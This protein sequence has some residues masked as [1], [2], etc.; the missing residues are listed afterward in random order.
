MITINT[1]AATTEDFKVIDAIIEMETARKV[2]KVLGAKSY[3][4]STACIIDGEFI[5]VSEF[6]IETEMVEKLKKA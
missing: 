4:I 1:K 3:N 6:D 2:N 5:L